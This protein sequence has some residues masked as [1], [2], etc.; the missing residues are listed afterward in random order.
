[1]SVQ[2]GRL[3]WENRTASPRYLEKIAATLAPFGPDSNEVF[4]KNGLTVLYRAFHTTAESRRET[5][6]YISRSGSII[7]WDGRLDNRSDLVD[8]L[9]GS[10]TS[11][12][13][14]VEIVATAFDTW[15]T[16]SFAQ[17][18]GDWALSICRSD[19]RTVILAKDPIGLRHLYYRSANNELIWSSLLDPL[20]LFSGRQFAPCEEYL[21]GWLS[22]H[23]SP[24]LT[25]YSGICSVPPSFY[26]L[27]EPKRVALKQHWD[28]H[29]GHSIRYRTDTE[30]EEH[31][32]AV[33]A[34]AIQRRLRSD[35]PILAHLSG[36]MDSS[37]IVC[38]ADTLAWHS[39]H[40]PV[41]DTISWYDDSN[42]GLDERPYFTK[43]EE[44]RGKP[45]FHVDLQA[46]RYHQR[47]PEL[48]LSAFK[49]Q[50]FL[51]TPYSS[52]SHPDFFRL[53]GAC[54]ASNGHRVVLSGVGGDEV[55]GSGVPSP[56][57]ELQNLI[58][59]AQLIRLARQLD[60]WAIKMRKSR[61][62]LLWD[63]VRGFLVGLPAG[64]GLTN[65]P[66][67]S[68]LHPGFVSRNRAA[69]EGY[70]AR[71]RLFGALPSFQTQIATLNALRRIT[72]CLVCR[73]DSL[74]EMRYPYLDR[75]LMA[76][77]F[78]IPREQIVRVGQRRSL[79]KRALVGIVPEEILKRR[80]QPIL[81]G[82]AGFSESVDA[83][84]TRDYLLSDLG[85]VD[86]DN[87][88][89]A[90]RNLQGKQEALNGSLLRTIALEAWLRHLATRG[91]LRLSGLGDRS[92]RSLS[93]EKASA[94]ANIG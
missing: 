12:S 4:S 48:L 43:V 85:I 71:V 32:R 30:Y 70:P 52:D 6:P 39:S 25:P 33:F 83:M 54:I 81:A 65:S 67:G 13:T 46:L 86:A 37:S 1:M 62:L 44:K 20:V 40:Q 72:A 29:S 61:G 7:T 55:M 47:T 11:Q 76:Y 50:S 94:R 68:W 93:P 35:R 42:P 64:F 51:A 88:S 75:C 77:M 21:A 27:F 82:E 5:Q 16:A 26:V 19:A 45:G 14:D 80:Q 2:F 57:P 41:V 74:C 23:P 60:A 56:R 8:K 90:L 38:M 79:M 84:G 17:L 22:G 36:G 92:F 10:L 3:N 58:A 53:Y 24:R 63:A 31:F 91:L 59:R 78:A 49:S 18:I 66:T 87:L 28:F 89:E 73:P 15:G 34:T 9:K 69:L